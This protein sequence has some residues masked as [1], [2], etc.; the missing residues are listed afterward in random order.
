MSKVTQLTSLRPL[1]AQVKHLEVECAER[2]HEAAH[3]IELLEQLPHVFARLIEIAPARERAGLSRAIFFVDHELDLTLAN[4]RA[5]MTC[6]CV[7]H[8]RFVAGRAA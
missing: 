5:V 4:L 8:D 7:V 3:Q 6:C 2:I 1:E